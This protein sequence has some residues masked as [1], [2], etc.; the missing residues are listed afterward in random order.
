MSNCGLQLT[1][2]ETQIQFFL[3]QSVLFVPYDHI[4]ILFFNFV[5]TVLFFLCQ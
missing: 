4:T 2:S 3:G 1:F 5:D